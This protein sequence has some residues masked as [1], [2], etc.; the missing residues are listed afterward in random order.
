MAAAAEQH[1]DRVVLT[2]TDLAEA[3]AA[4]ALVRSLN[5][6]AEIVSGVAGDVAAAELIGLGAHE[7]CR[8][9]NLLTRPAL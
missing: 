1:A 8:A 9:R 4:E 7:P 2:K 3:D 6:V 5:P